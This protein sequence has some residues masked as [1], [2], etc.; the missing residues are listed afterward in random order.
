[1]LVSVGDMNMQDGFCTRLCGMDLGM[2]KE[3]F[4]MERALTCTIPPV[5]YRTQRR[6]PNWN[7]AIQDVLK[8]YMWRWEEGT[9]FI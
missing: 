5:L 4:G 7:L 2:G 6:I 9:H 1:M 3:E 8:V